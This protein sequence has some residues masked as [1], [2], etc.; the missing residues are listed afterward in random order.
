MNPRL[1]LPTGRVGHLQIASVPERHEPDT[2]ELNCA[3]LFAVIDEISA[4]TGWNGCI[5]C[6]YRPARG[7]TPGGTSAG[8]DWTRARQP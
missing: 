8:L 6:E 2:G 5:G 7:S 3:Y 1:D 4:A